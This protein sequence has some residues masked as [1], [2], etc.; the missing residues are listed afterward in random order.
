MV[1]VRN[2]LSKSDKRICYIV[3]DGNIFSVFVTPSTESVF[4]V[5]NESREHPTEPDGPKYF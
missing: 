5:A 4:Q 1:E 3:L 2:S